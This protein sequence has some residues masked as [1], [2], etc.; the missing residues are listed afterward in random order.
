MNGTGSFTATTTTTV[1]SR[2]MS[3]SSPG[4]CSA[5]SDD[6]VLTPQS[7]TAENQHGLPTSTNGHLSDSGVDF[8]DKGDSATFKKP[9]IVLKPAPPPAVN[10]WFKKNAA[11]Q[12]FQL[13]PVQQKSPVK[14]IVPKWQA[15]YM[16]IDEDESKQFNF[17]SGNQAQC[18]CIFVC[19]PFES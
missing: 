4:S 12:E 2:P 7:Q 9:D 16:L 19:I 10:P 14:E 6:S 5:S 1:A 3:S 15:P 18:R 11:A 13:P 8:P 17:V